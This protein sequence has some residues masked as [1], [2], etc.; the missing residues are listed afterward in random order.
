MSESEKCSHCGGDC[1]P[2]CGRH[3]AGCIYGGFSIYSSYWLVAEGCTLSHGEEQE[4]E[5]AK[6]AG[7]KDFSL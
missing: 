6:D 2:E 4:D 3:P 5:K 7:T 1:A